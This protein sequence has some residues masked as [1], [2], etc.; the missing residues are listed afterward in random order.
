LSDIGNVVECWALGVRRAEVSKHRSAAIA[1]F[2]NETQRGYLRSGYGVQVIDLEGKVDRREVTE[3]D[4]KRLGR[5]NLLTRPIEELRLGLSYVAVRVD[6][7]AG[8]RKWITK[9]IGPQTRD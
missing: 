8:Q 6:N 3:G 1:S 5:A 2:V 7:R 4:R 9:Q